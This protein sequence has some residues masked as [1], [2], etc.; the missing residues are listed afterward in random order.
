MDWY[1]ITVHAGQEFRVKAELDRRAS[2]LP[3]GNLR[4]AAVPTERT[5]AQR[6]GLTIH[7]ES[8]RLPGYVLVRARLTDEVWALLRTT[9]GVAGIVGATNEPVPLTK[10]E[11]DRLL[12][13]T[14]LPRP[15]RAPFEVGDA[16][17]ITEGPLI[18]LSGTVKELNPD[19]ATAKVLVSM[20]DREI[21]AQ[22]SFDQVK[23]R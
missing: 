14:P 23:A 2:R 22:V 10:L 15:S 21:P 11:V 9:A 12:G 8:R 16:V 18:G 13:A 6:G 1:A 17:E 7:T 5:S 20:F 3:N 4:E 19:A